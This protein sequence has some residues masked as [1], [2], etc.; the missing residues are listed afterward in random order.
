VHGVESL[1]GREERY[2]PLLNAIEAVL[3]KAYAA[4]P[5]MRDVDALEAVREARRAVGRHA[6]E[7]SRTARSILSSVMMARRADRY[8]HEEVMACLCYVSANIR[9]Q[10]GSD[11]ASEYLDSIAEHVS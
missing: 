1:D 3:R 7:T 10:A 11:G 9:R 6:G 4:S 5:R 8:T 2:I